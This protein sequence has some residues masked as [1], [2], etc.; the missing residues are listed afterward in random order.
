MQLPPAK[1][2]GHLSVSQANRAV[3]RSIPEHKLEHQADEYGHR[4]QTIK[5]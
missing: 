1:E 5:R 3:T 2:T 4:F